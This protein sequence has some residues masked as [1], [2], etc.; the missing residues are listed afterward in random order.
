M[1]STGSTF[2][3]LAGQQ[4]ADRA[5]AIVVGLVDRDDRRG[6]GGAIAFQHRHAAELLVD[7]VVG[8]FADLLSAA[9]DEPQA[10]QLVAFGCRA[11]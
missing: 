10:R 7:Q 4:A 5:A 1:P 2:H 6:L 8:L 9:D 11:Y 3:F